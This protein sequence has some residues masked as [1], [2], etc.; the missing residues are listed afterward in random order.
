MNSAVR[1]EIPE[2]VK[3]VTEKLLSHGHR[4]Y[5]VGG[6]V[7]DSLM[8]TV[9]HD[10]DIC[11]DALPEDTAEIFSHFSV[12][13]TGLKHGT[14][15]VRS[16]GHPV[17]IT[18]FR[19]ESEYS[20][21]R[22]PDSV[23]F[24]SS[25]ELDLSRRDFTVNAIAYCEGEGTVDL[26][27]GREDI[28]NGIIRAIGCPR[29]RFCE[30]K[31]RILRAL[32]FSS[33]LGFTVEDS[34]D[35]AILEMKGEITAVSPERI[36]EELKKAIVGDNFE[37]VFTKY[38]SV[39]AEIIPELLPCI[40]Y[41][42]NNP[43]HDFP[44]H[45]HLARAV[46]ACPHDYAVRIAALLHDIGKPAVM[47]RD[48]DG[49]SHFYSHAATSAALA[50]GILKRLRF[51]A[52][53]TEK[54]ITLIRNHDGVIEE[55]E[56]SVKHKLNKLGRELF[57]DLIAI[58][59]ADSSAQKA[60]PSQRVGHFDTLC[61][62]AKDILERKECF[63]LKDLAVNGNDL[64]VLGYRGKEIGSALSYLLEAVLNGELANDKDTLLFALDRKT[65]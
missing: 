46:S 53:D 5:L 58:Q 42:Q 24:S 16:D 50:E 3:K 11:T 57:F 13:S 30:D 61:Q 51:S 6:C 32:R 17:E 48:K 25:L 10:Y 18:T 59:R 19:R 63:S 14:V 31:L 9:P 1:I 8:G 22:H 55:S 23:Q 38:T 12:I 34:T 64:I 62:I 2:Y 35:R 40:D 29:E 39:F 56:R 43:H 36:S 47:S 15:T 20:D 7:R 60:C 33:V 52:L 49:I 54:I 28:E 44:L 4:A 45:I 65:I 26:F 21:G 27:H 37:A 41:D